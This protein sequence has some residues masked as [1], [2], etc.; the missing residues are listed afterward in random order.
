[1]M[2]CYC[3]TQNALYL[4]LSAAAAG[5]V[6]PDERSDELLSVRQLSGSERR[7]VD[8]VRLSRQALKTKTPIYCRQLP[9]NELMSFVN[10]GNVK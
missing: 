1:M 5:S 3:T 10:T 2:K 9:M 8:I 4:T 6:R 7:P